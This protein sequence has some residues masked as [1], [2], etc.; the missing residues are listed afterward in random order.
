VIA[1]ARGEQQMADASLTAPI[2][3]D[4][5]VEATGV[6]N[7]IEGTAEAVTV[8]APTSLNVDDYI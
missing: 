7:I 4:L 3:L 8:T 2:T 5:P 1:M 6:P